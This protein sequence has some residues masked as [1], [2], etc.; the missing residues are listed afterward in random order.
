MELCTVDAFTQRQSMN[1]FGLDIKSKVRLLKIYFLSKTYL[2]LNKGYEKKDATLIPTKK[3]II[4]GLKQLKIEIKVWQEEMKEK[5]ED[6]PVVIF[7]PN[8]VDIAYQFKGT[9]KLQ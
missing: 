2:V 9:L 6:D 1:C 5:F 4:D 7:R 3:D 8:E